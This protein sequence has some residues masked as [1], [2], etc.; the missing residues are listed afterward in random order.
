MRQKIPT[1]SGYNLQKVN[2]EPYL[3]SNNNK[4]ITLKVICEPIPISVSRDTENLF[5]K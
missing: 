1:N 3:L 4:T 5:T 2:T